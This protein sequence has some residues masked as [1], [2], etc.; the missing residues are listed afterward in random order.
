MGHV[1]TD[2]A[3]AHRA[4]GHGR[5]ERPKP[6]VPT[7]GTSGVEATGV[8]ERVRRA[9]GTCGERP[10]GTPEAQREEAHSTQTQKELPARWEGNQEKEA[11]RMPSKRVS[12]RE[13]KPA[14]NAAERSGKIKP[15]K[16]PLDLVTSRSLGTL[17]RAAETKGRPG[18]GPGGMRKGEGQR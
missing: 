2:R 10:N 17:A 11:A 6:E 14:S 12:R 3:A 5:E 18:T 13:R 15:E 1:E 9:R 7:W 4:N 8:A 16:C